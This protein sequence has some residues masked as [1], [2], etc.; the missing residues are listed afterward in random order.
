MNEI[1]TGKKKNNKNKLFQTKNPNQ[2]YSEQKKTVKKKFRANNH[3][4]NLN[5]FRRFTSLSPPHTH[6]H[7][8]SNRFDRDSVSE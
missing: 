4:K 3:S 6:T 1:R 7:H 8:R 2:T 5:L